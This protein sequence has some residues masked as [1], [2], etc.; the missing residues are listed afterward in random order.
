MKTLILALSLA[1]TALVA[2]PLSAQSISE[3]DKRIGAQANPELVAQYGGAMKGPAAD[4]VARVGRRIAVQS[5][6]SN[7]ERDF[8]VTLLDSSVENAFAI[9]G[10][11]VYVTRGLLALMND[12]AE[13][14]SVMGHEVGHVAA[15]HAASRQRTSTITSVLAGLAG[16]VAGNSGL[17]SLVGR[18]A[19]VGADLITKGFSRSQEYQADDLGV[20]YLASGG[21]DPTAAADML[22][23][24]DATKS[25]TAKTTGQTNSIP[26]W[27]STHPNSADRVTRAENK[28]RETGRQGG[29]RNRAAFLAAIDGLVYGD[30]PA[31]GYM[32]GRVFK[33]P[34]ERLSFAVPF[35]FTVNNG[36]AA[37]TIAGSNG[38]AIFAGGKAGGTLAAHVD[39]VFRGLS[40]NGVGHGQ[41]STTKV[42]DLPMAYSFGQAN[43]NAGV[44]DVGVFAYDFGGGKAFHFVTLTRSGAGIG[45]FEPLINSMKRMSEEEARTARPMRIKVVTV[46]AGDT[47]A[48]LSKQMAYGDYQL[49]R[50]LTINGLGPDAPLRAGDKVKLVVR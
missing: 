28:A 40:Q 38:Q 21:Y 41:I 50:F 19:G 5:G 35:N 20:R 45:P 32:E 18:G 1:T 10:G 12:E 15:R 11:Y 4:Y 49:D 39:S 17:G 22:A 44:L 36:D 29:E 48:S 33:L 8:T 43:S 30:D 25:L 34:T 27:A 26:T 9:P 16:A 47:A 42:G 23:Q 46:K 24:L 13:L 14:A 37:V 7:S 31:K 2:T 3:G 6:L